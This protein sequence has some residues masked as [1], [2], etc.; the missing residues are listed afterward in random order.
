MFLPL[1]TT[2]CAILF[3]CLEIMKRLQDPT[4]LW[5]LHEALVLA[6]DNLPLVAQELVKERHRKPKGLR[7]DRVALW[8]P[9]QAYLY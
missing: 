1:I 4:K 5:G 7:L 3:A 8:S 9:E 2:N 6:V